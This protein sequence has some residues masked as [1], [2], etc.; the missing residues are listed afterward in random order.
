MIS[1]IKF[2]LCRCLR[3]SIVRGKSIVI[4]GIGIVE[5][6]A[7]PIPV[8]IADAYPRHWEALVGGAFPIEEGASFFFY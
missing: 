5:W 1:N 6:D 8:M 3:I 2:Y 4:S 7:K